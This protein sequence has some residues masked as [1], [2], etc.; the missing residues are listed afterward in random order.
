MNDLN[1]ELMSISDLRKMLG[2]IGRTTAYKIMSA[3]EVQT[4][5]INRRRLPVR[6]SANAYIQRLI[7]RAE[8]R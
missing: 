7:K 6:S 8:A 3:G 1:E 4:V 5:K 2:G